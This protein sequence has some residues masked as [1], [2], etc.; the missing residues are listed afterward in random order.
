MGSGLLGSTQLSGR[1]GTDWLVPGMEEEL[2]TE[3]IR[4]LPKAKRRLL[5]PAPEVGA[6]V[7]A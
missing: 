6:E 2:A 1:V 3:M 7:T 4:A 5:A